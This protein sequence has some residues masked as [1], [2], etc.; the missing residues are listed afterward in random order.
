MFVAREKPYVLIKGTRDGLVFKM[1]DTCSF[2]ELIVELKDKLN[3]SL[4]RFLQSS[5]INRVTIQLGYRYLKPEQEQ[6]LKDLIR[7]SPGNLVVDK[8]ESELVPKAELELAKQQSAVKVIYKT[9]RS[10]QVVE[11]M[12]HL[13]IVGDVNPGSM[14]QATGNIYVMGALRG[15]AHAGCAGDEQAIIAA[16]CLQPTQLRIAGLVSRSPDKWENDTAVREFAYIDQGQ[17][18]VEK[19]NQLDTIRPQLTNIV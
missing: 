16:N 18:I 11:C 17:I 14:V 4:D 12:G 6:E 9:I 15:M 10:G 19:L 7:L 5:T 8:L 13:L 2:E 3:V 1:D